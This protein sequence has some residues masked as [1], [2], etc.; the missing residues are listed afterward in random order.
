MHVRLILGQ[1]GMYSSLSLYIFSPLQPI[2]V[3]IR[4]VASCRLFLLVRGVGN[5]LL[6]VVLVVSIWSLNI[7]ISLDFSVEDFAVCLCFLLK[8]FKRAAKS[9]FLGFS[10]S[11]VFSGSIFLQCS[12]FSWRK[13]KKLLV[14]CL[15]M[16][17]AAGLESSTTMPSETP[18]LL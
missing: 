14:G 10:S 8:F 16:K 11:W 2:F 7:F 15:S 18:I 6:E 17:L 9:S 1:F 12:L 4:S 3:K 5:F 13:L